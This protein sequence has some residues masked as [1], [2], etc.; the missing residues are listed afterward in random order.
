[1]PSR[2]A[3]RELHTAD[4]L[5]EMDDADLLAPEEISEGGAP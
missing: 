4:E 3:T 2:I 5:V 1:L